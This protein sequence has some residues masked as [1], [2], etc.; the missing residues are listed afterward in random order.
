MPVHCE[1]SSG[2]DSVSRL[3]AYECRYDKS[4][5]HGTWPARRSLCILRF[6]GQA[7]RRCGRLSSNV[8][9]HVATASA[10]TVRA[11]AMGVLAVLVSLLIAMALPAELLDFSHRGTEAGPAPGVILSQSEMQAKEAAAARALDEAKREQATLKPSDIASALASRAQ[12]VAMVVL[13]LLLLW[14]RRSSAWARALA[15]LPSIVLVLVG[16]QTLLPLP[17]ITVLVVA[18]SLLPMKQTAGDA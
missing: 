5:E 1:P 6:A 3:S 7:P 17:A 14:L 12:W 2:L 11:F 18:P 9:H 10:S 8:R 13:A 16:S 15:A 4:V